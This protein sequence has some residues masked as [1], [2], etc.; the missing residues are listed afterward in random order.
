[1]S[2][3]RCI[4]IFIVLIVLICSFC[5]AANP[6]VQVNGEILDFTD[7]NG[8]K[9]EA[10]IINDRT[11]VPLRKIFEV[12]NCE[13]DW[14]GET[15]TVIATKGNQ[16]ITLQ[17]GNEVAEVSDTD[18][19]TKR[20]VTLDSAPVIVE[21]RTLVPFRFIGESLGMEVAWDGANST[22]IIIDYDSFAELIKAKNKTLYDLFTDKSGA[23]HE[24]TFT[25]KYFDEADSS[26]DNSIIA[27][28]M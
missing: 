25:K 4:T 16:K 11:M 14:D 7:S 19:S 12:L 17:I 1:M 21:G 6:S 9:V 18:T 26:N 10:Q 2:I 24:L 23:G 13:V 28:L 20:E 8:N 3:K 22:A 15:Q 5:F 27:N